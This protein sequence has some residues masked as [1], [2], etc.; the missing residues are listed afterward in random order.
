MAKYSFDMKE[1]MIKQMLPPENIP[2]SELADKN[3][4]CEQ[5]LYKW[6]KVAKENGAVMQNHSN[7]THKYSNEAKLN[8][9]IE[10]AHLNQQELSEYCR[11]KGIYAD[12]INSWKTMFV[13]GKTETE[14]TIK[15]ELKSKDAELKSIKKELRRKEKALAEAAAILVLRKKMNAIWNSD[16]E[17]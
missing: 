8:I 5:T 14:T 15:E 12:E 2:V 1:K 7:A 6:K 16:E 11:K 10:T 9:I 4:I 17:D 13:T 3:K